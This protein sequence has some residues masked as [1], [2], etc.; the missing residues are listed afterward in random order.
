MNQTH[1]VFG[2]SGTM[3]QALVLRLLAEEMP[4]RAAV[5]N[6]ERAQERLPDGVEIVAA[7]ATDLTAMQAACEGAA[8]IHNCVYVPADEWP[9]VTENFITAARQTGARLVFP[10]NI[11]PYGPLQKV[12]AT[13]DHPLAATSMRGQIRIRIEKTLTAAMQAGD[14]Q[15][16]IPRLPGFYGPTIR[17]GF[18]HAIFKAALAKK[19][20]EWYGSL[21]MPYD[22]LY[23]DD[24]AMAFMLLGTA[25][26]VTGQV[27]HVPG[28]GPLTGREFITMV[29]EAAG[30]T[31]NMSVRD[32]RSFQTLGLIYKPARSY[33]EVLYEFEQPLVMDGSKFA[34]A[35]PDFEYTPHDV[36]IRETVEFLQ[37]K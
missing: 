32:R 33:L 4:V 8:V 17:D 10:S 13:E 6:V 5:R 31:P 18:L 12:P 1:V 23:A 24:A 35:F 14:A 37:Q 16:V 36:A 29:C 34:Q 26:G 30:T 9:V 25:E 7:D 20:A 11:H 2:A 22:L 27:W 3:G 21:D 15:I 28:A 19:K